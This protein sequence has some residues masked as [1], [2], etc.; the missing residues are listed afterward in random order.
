MK[1]D[2]NFDI[3]T[4]RITNSDEQSDDSSAPSMNRSSQII[5]D[6]KRASTVSDRAQP[7]E[8]FDPFNPATNAGRDDPTVGQSAKPQANIASTKLRQLINNLPTDDI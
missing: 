1:I 7:R 5:N 6:L 2:L 8:G 3:D 4:L